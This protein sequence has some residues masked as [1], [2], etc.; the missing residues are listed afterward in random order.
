MALLIRFRTLLGS[1]L[2]FL[3][4][5][6]SPARIPLIAVFIYLF[7]AVYSVG[8]GPVPFAY[9]AEVFPLTHREVGMGFGVATCFFWAAV[10]SLTW[11]RLVGALGSTGAFGF[12][13]G[14]SV[15]LHCPL[16]ESTSSDTTQDSTSSLSS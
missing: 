4:Q 14:E 1:G 5:V 13:A 10:L 6:G 8:E 9:G 16:S 11:P 2:C 3:I 7:C 15:G 12:Y